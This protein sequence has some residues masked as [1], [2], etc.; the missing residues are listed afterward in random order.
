M[1]VSR[2]ITFLKF[3]KA[4]SKAVPDQSV[5]KNLE[6]E[7]SYKKELLMSGYISGE[8]TIF[9]KIKQLESGTQLTYLKE[10]KRIKDE[11]PKITFFFI[12]KCLIVE[13]CGCEA[14]LSF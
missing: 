7:L 2:K 8:R 4:Y 1:G 3:K 6:L 11:I 5:K 9:K 10:K 14:L 12:K 13:Y